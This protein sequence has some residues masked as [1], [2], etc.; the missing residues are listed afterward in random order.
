MG[1]KKSWCHEDL[2]AW[3][4]VRAPT[5]PVSVRSAFSHSTS[6]TVYSRCFIGCRS[7][8]AYDTFALKF[9]FLFL[10]SSNTKYFLNNI[11]TRAS[12]RFDRVKI[13]S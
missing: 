10:L 5:P 13:T 12:R 11:F 1:D 7:L 8:A 6:K 4:N 9:L 2:I 3:I